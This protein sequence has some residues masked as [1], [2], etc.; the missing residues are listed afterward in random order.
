MYLLDNESMDMKDTTSKTRLENVSFVLDRGKKKKFA[1]FRLQ[2]DGQ[3]I[4]HI[5]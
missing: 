3:P 2:P 4:N 5:H 1:T